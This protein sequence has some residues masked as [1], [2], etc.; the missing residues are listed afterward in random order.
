MTC[1][2]FIVLIATK[3]SA[4]F[5][6]QIVFCLLFTQSCDSY[7]ND[8]IFDKFECCLC[9]DEAPYGLFLSWLHLHKVMK[10]VQKKKTIYLNWRGFS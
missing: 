2:L 9:G 3:L 7:E 1:T 5:E 10:N 4:M 6:T 8:S